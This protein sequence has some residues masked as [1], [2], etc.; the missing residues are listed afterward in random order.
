MSINRWA[1]GRAVVDDLLKRGQL[2]RVAASRD[3]ADL[4]ID[5]AVKHLESARLLAPVDTAGAFQLAYDAARKALAAVLANQ[6]LRARGAGAHATL[7]EAVRAQLHPPLGRDLEPF[8]WMRPLRNDTEY[9]SLDRPVA[10]ADDVEEA[11]AAAA[12]IIQRASK[13][14]GSM[15]VY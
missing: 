8:G 1:Q 9:P 14:L 11:T 6:G 7:Y 5:Q 13:V 15:P 10:T 4:M 2:E 3:L 12:V